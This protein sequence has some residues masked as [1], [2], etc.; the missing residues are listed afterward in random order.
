M[1][2]TEFTCAFTG[3]SCVAANHEFTATG[4]AGQVALRWLG[5][6]CDPCLVTPSSVGGGSIGRPACERSA[7]NTPV[8]WR[9]ITTSALANTQESDER[10]SKRAS[11]IARRLTGGELT[12]LIGVDG[13]WTLGEVVGSGRALA[14]NDVLDGKAVRLTGGNRGQKVVEVFVYSRAE[15]AQAQHTVVRYVAGG[16]RCSKGQ[17]GMWHSELRKIESLRPPL[18]PKRAFKK[19]AKMPGEFTLAPSH[20]AKIDATI[21]ADDAFLAASQSDSIFGGVAAAGN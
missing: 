17:C 9:E 8:E 7:Y 3:S 19:V 16:Q 21:I 12:A 5:C 14:N 6:A 11:R 20:A 10:I 18:V 13:S 4:K 15:R 2:H 1:K